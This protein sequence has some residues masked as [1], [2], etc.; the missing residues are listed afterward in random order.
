MTP[1]R[2]S[3]GCQPFWLISEV[4]VFYSMFSRAFLVT[5]IYAA[6]SGTAIAETISVKYRG[7]VPLDTFR[8]ATIDRSSLVERVCYDATQE[9]MLIMLQGTYYHY[10]EIDQGTVDGLLTAPSL[11]KYFNANIKGTGSDGPFDCRTHR[12]PEY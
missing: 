7:P 8:C 10:C 11:G 3:G 4:V 2:P 6:L 9:Y 12:M 5:W 1:A